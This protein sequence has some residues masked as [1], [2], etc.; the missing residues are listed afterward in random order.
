MENA[1]NIK[2]LQMLK[3]CQTRNEQLVKALEVNQ[4]L[5]KELQ[6]GMLLQLIMGTVQRLM[7][8]EA[9]SLF[10]LDDQTGDLVFQVALGEAGARLKELY[11]LPKGTGVAGWVAASGRSVRIND[12]YADERFD[13]SYDE[14]TGFRTHNMLCAPVYY[15]DALIGVCQVINR[16]DGDFSADDLKLL[17]TLAQMAAIAIENARVHQRLLK[18]SLLDRDLQLAH[19]L[20]QSFLP[21]SPP[22]VEGYECAFANRSA[23]EV[24][25]DFYDAFPLPDGRI[26]YALGDVS[27]KG[28]AAALMMSRLLKDLRLEAMRGGAAGDMLGRL[29]QAFAAGSWQGMFASV[30]LLLLHPEDGRVEV[31]NAGHLPPAHIFDGDVGL[32]EAASGPPVGILAAS[33]Y[34]TQE[35]QLRAGETLLLYTDGVT[36]AKNPA[37]ELAGSGQMLAWLRNA[38][39]PAGDCLAYVF[40]RVG[41]FADA[42]PQSDDITLLALRRRAGS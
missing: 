10:L 32:G 35:L 19:Q 24:G 14:R 27:G 15:R 28:V 40:E 36:E 26:A 4:L 38:P 31:A 21:S 8:A 23:F 1:T 13:S 9:C 12:T 29:N 7:Q 20:Q 34:A 5:S 30:I 16:M 18:Q 41:C 33:T 3:R 25:G 22:Q 37:G 11:R 6:L 39:A 42:S 17:E 2:A